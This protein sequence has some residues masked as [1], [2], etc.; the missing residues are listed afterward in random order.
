VPA[1][2][3]DELVYDEA[4]RAIERQRITASELRAGASLLIATAAIAIALLDESTFAGDGAPFAW[5]A[6]ASFLT[7]SLSALAVIWPRR[8]VPGAP[9][10]MRHVIALTCPGGVPAEALRRELIMSLAVHHSHGAKHI[11][12][13]V[14]AFQTGAGALIVQLVATV[15]AL[16]LTT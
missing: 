8:G 11:T 13:L 14:R 15:A 6:L 3:P 16:I 5:L 12:R 7:V 2:T 10:L 4:I 1:A 9:D